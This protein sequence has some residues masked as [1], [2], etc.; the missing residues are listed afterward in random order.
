MEFAHKL[1]S[2]LTKA[3][4]GPAWSSRSSR[5]SP[6]MSASKSWLVW[7]I[8]QGLLVLHPLTNVG[9]GRGTDV[10]TDTGRETDSKPGGSD[11]V[12]DEILVVGGSSSTTASV[13]G[14]WADTG[15]WIGDGTGATTQLSW[16]SLGTSKNTSGTNKV[17]D[18]CP[19]H[20]QLSTRS[21]KSAK[22]TRFYIFNWRFPMG[23][24]NKINLVNDTFWE[25]TDT[26]FRLWSGKVVS[27][28]VTWCILITWSSQN[29]QGRLK[30]NRSWRTAIASWAE[31]INNQKHQMSHNINW[32]LKH[33]HTL[34][35]I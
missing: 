35:L 9:T 30:Q 19:A 4:S 33:T 27:Y 3:D 28:L 8:G 18:C 12:T 2:S 15:G 17:S 20:F 16:V 7:R 5:S 34:L 22:L 21:W 26:Y 23:K 6:M 13:R 31:T 25:S 14:E 11:G 10:V 32:F 29:I 1:L 24:L